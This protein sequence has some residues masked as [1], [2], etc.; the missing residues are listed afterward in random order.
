MTWIPK[1]E[2]IKAVLMLDGEKR[3]TYCIKKM[4]DEQ[5]LWSL[6]HSDGWALSSDDAGHELLPV[7]PHEKFASLCANG[8]WADYHP[9]AIDIDAWLDRWIAG[10]EKDGKLVAVFPAP[11][12]G[13]VAVE[14]RRMES[15]LRDELLQYE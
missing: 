12:D 15:D 7:W 6:R 1:E 13:G 11:Q 5:Q 8:A 3:Y 2:E 9:V 10:M 14:P 4:A